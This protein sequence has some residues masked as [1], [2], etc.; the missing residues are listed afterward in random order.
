VLVSV[1]LKASAKQTTFSAT[2]VAELQSAVVVEVT[3]KILEEVAVVLLVFTETV[4][5]PVV[6]SVGTV[7]VN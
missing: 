1:A 5:A 2:V 4:M 3:V 7:T 6:A